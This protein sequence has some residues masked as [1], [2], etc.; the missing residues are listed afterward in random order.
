M[1][2]DQVICRTAGICA[3]RSPISP[4]HILNAS[5]MNYFGLKCSFDKSNVTK[6]QITHHS[7]VMTKSTTL[8]QEI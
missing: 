7:R 1:F 4:M 5:G 2:K 8:R 6:E 3:S